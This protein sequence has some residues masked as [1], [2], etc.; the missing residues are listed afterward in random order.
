MKRRT[1]LV[2]NSSSASFILVGFAVPKTR[3]SYEEILTKLALSELNNSLEVYENEDYGAPEGMSLIGIGDYHHAENTTNIT[4]IQK[5][6]A[7]VEEAR[8]V[9]GAEK[10][11]LRLYVSTVAC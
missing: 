4:D 9:F 1:S 11:T 5:V 8:E 10:E 2:S 7:D 6:L 3:I